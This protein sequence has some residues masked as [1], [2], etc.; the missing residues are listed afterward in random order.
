MS[1]DLYEVWRDDRLID[2]AAR[3]DLLELQDDP[4]AG[5]LVA[6]SMLADSRPLPRLDVDAAALVESRHSHRYAVRSLAV[7]VTVVAT[8]STSGVAAVVTGDPLRPAKAVW[9]QIQDHTGLRA[10]AEEPQADSDSALGVPAVQPVGADASRPSDLAVPQAASRADGLTAR[11]PIRPSGQASD[12]DPAT[13]ED[14]QAHGDVDQTEEGPQPTYPEDDAQQSDEQARSQEPADTEGQEPGDEPGS[15]PTPDDEQQPA[16][17]DGS[18]DDL[19]DLAQPEAP[20]QGPGELA[21]TRR[22]LPEDGVA[23][24]EQVLRRPSDETVPVAPEGTLQDTVQGT[25]DGTSTDD[26][27]DG[28]GDASTPAPPPTLAP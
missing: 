3:G 5:P 2:A 19:E 10:D 25:I 6:L 21:P 4:A 8:L 11:A 15:Q 14:A 1:D 27:V 28:A 7:A 24:Q 20:D 22:V 23:D 9:H 18:D 17:D 13:T 26:V 12:D 16:P